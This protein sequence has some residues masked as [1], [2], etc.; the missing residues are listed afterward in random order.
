MK[1]TLNVPPIVP[2]GLR[3]RFLETYNNNIEI[4]GEPFIEEEKYFLPPEDW[5]ACLEG[6]DE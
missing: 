1:E 6:K 4:Y 3:D 2:E 5:W